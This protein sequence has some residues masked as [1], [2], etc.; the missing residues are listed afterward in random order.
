MHTIFSNVGRAKDTD[1]TRLCTAYL[2]TSMLGTVHTARPEAVFVA[3]PGL[4]RQRG[5]AASPE[6]RSLGVVRDGGS[7][8]LQI[9]R[10]NT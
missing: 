5:G 10:F 9:H 4:A 7:R 8:Q 3:Q 1:N 2:Y 6:G